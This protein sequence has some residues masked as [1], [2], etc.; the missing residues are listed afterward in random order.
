MDHA[1]RQGVPHLM[2]SRLL[3]LAGL[4]YLASG[5]QVT[6]AVREAV[7]LSC[8]YNISVNELERVRVYWQK[9]RQV[10]LSITSGRTEVWTG[11]ENRTTLDIPNNLSLVILTLRLSDRGTY[12]CVVQKPEKN[13]FKLQHLSSVMLSIR[14]DF[15]VPSITDLGNLSTNI[16]RI[17][18]STSGGFPKPRLSWLENGEEID[19]TNTSISQDPLTELFTVSSELDFNMT[20]NHSFK[21]LIKYG[22]TTVSET[23]SWQKPQQQDGRDNPNNQL[24][25]WMSFLTAVS[26]F[27]VIALG[28]LA[29]NRFAPRWRERRRNEARLQIRTIYSEPERQRAEQN[30]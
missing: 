29:C 27:L 19:A 10:V 1:L 6:K 5:R 28:A 14:A 23:F 22:D 8:E 2:L 18:C 21:C 3:V 11:Y 30:V 20:S 24:S 4:L 16:K 17:L 7:M 12:S 15:L 25:V 13:G 9:D 26:V